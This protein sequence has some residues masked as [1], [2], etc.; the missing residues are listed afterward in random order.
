MYGIF[1]LS[2]FST[3]SGL[4]RRKPDFNRLITAQF[5][6]EGPKPNCP[7]TNSHQTAAFVVAVDV[8]AAVVVD[9]DVLNVAAAAELHLL[10]SPQK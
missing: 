6:P 3:G 1:S 4:G 2:I 5:L 8:D 10:R 7:T 9:V